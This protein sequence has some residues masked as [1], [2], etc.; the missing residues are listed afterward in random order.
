MRAEQL[1]G[2]LPG[3]SKCANVFAFA[4]VLKDVAR[5]VAVGN[6]D[7]SIGGHRQI[8]RTVLQRFAI[9]TGLRIRF[10][11]LRV[12]QRENFL[13]VQGCLCNEAALNVAQIEKLRASF[14]ANEQPMCAASKLLA[15][16]LHKLPMSIE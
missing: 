4:V 14:L 1:T 3:P 11:L 9:R 7:V 12:P 15:P 16:A 8:G 13:T 10:R 5:T 6:I 2:F